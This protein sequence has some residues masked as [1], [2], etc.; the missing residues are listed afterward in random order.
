MLCKF[1]NPLFST[2]KSQQ[3]KMGVTRFSTTL[4][5][6]NIKGMFQRHNKKLLNKLMPE[7]TVFCEGPGYVLCVV[8]MNCQAL[9]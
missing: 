8:K 1:H 9:C 2:K 5:H 6:R 7:I 3:H 4:N